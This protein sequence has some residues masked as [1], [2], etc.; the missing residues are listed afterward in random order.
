MKLEDL[1][2]NIFESVEEAIKMVKKNGILLLFADE[3]MQDNKE[4]VLA[5]VSDSA[6]AIEFASDR[7]K[8]DREVVLAAAGA[9][10]SRL[11]EFIS[12]DYKD[13]KEF[14]LNAV[15]SNG[16]NLQYA[17]NSLRD[18]KDVVLAAVSE[19]GEALQYASD[20]LRDDK[21]IVLAAVSKKGE[22]LRYASNSLR[23][24][25]D[26][27]LAAVSKKGEALRYASDSLKNDKEVILS[28]INN[29]GDITSIWDDIGD[30][31]KDPDIVNYETFMPHMRFFTYSD[32]RTHLN[33]YSG[34]N[35]SELE[36]C[37]KIK[38]FDESAENLRINDK[39]VALAGVKDGRSDILRFLSD[40]LKN[41]KDVVLA[42]CSR[43][44][45]SNE[46]KYASNELKQ[47]KEFVL[48]LVM[49]QGKALEDVSEELQ[50]DR[51]VVLAAVKS[52]GDALKYAGKE[53]QN[54]KDIVLAAVS[55][56]SWY[57]WT[58]E[59]ASEKLRNDKDVVSAAI[60]CSGYALKYAGAEL[61][62]DKAIVL[63]AVS[64]YGEA[65]EYAS[66]NLQ[67]D[68]DVVLA[69]VNANGKALKY[70]SRVLQ[71]DKDIVMDAI[72][73]NFNAYD[74]A[75]DTA[76]SNI[77]IVKLAVILGYSVSHLS[78]GLRW[79]INNNRTSEIS[80]KTEIGGMVKKLKIKNLMHF[81]AVHNL[82]G[83]IERNGLISRKKLEDLAKKGEIKIVKN[84]L[85]IND[86]IMKNKYV[87]ISD[88]SRLDGM[89]DTVS[90]SIDKCNTRML[91]DKDKEKKYDWI[92]LYIDPG[93]LSYEKSYFFDDNAAN[94]KYIKWEGKSDNERSER[95]TIFDFLSMFDF[96]FKFINGKTISVQT[97]V[98]CSEVNLKYIKKIEFEF[99]EDAEPYREE[100]ENRNI[101]IIINDGY[102]NN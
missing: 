85:E 44:I 26:I 4:I 13:D 68:R 47:D 27:V 23:D 52:H 55:S 96:Q 17:S 78:S 93:V 90:L 16:R 8:S 75:G 76:K 28:Y 25:K 51:D 100:L 32:I 38:W 11:F 67:G 29:G 6:N 14:M 92:K 60:Q 95:Y 20:S 24:D 89:K 5:A 62:N 37:Y 40:A 91:Y 61:Q 9:F 7:L 81:T 31:V 22:A 74:Y 98:M 82:D 35:F 73:E 79:R 3:E 64:S 36:K 63:A 80:D 57:S 30:L 102:F 101:E 88:D 48:S 15:S 97:E 58:L 65:L 2:K 53:L 49:N 18:D 41:D 54:D 94:S 84:R 87:C 99:E 45:Y 56:Y 12:K 34:I 59:Y 69:A 21:D 42:A 1:S 86:E 33:Y 39:D 83:I 43:K 77:G 72:I 70:A 10:K 66:Y 46:F 71:D 50:N 19:D